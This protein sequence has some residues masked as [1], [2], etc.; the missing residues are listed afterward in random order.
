M[1]C[2]KS[3]IIYT[4]SICRRRMQQNEL[5]RGNTFYVSSQRRIIVL[6]YITLFLTCTNI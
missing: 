4:I 2:D 6:F 3:I 5:V 1:R